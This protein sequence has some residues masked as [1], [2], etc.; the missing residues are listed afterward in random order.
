MFPFDDVI[1]NFQVSS[2][3]EAV[4]VFTDEYPSGMYKAGIIQCMDSAHER[5]PSLIDRTHAQ[6]DPC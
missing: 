4:P 3:E 1:T 2:H 5:R 6:D